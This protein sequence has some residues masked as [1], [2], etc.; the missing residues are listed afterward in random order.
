MIP[1]LSA[2]HNAQRRFAPTYIGLTILI[3][4]STFGLWLIALNMTANAAADF[5]GLILYATFGLSFL[6]DGVYVLDTVHRPLIT[7]V[8]TALRLAGAL[9]ILA[10]MLS[11]PT[12]PADPV[13]WALIWGAA[14][15]ILDVPWRQRSLSTLGKAVMWRM[16]RPGYP[17]IAAFVVVSS[18]RLIQILTLGGLSYGL[19]TALSQFI[20]RSYSSQ[21]GKTLTQVYALVIVPPAIL[22][23]N[24]LYYRVWRLA[25]RR[26][27]LVGHTESISAHNLKVQK[28]WLFVSLAVALIVLTY[29]GLQPVAPSDVVYV[30]LYAD[31]LGRTIAADFTGLSFEAPVLT[32]PQF[33]NQNT[34]LIR[35]LENLGSGTLRFGGNALEDTY[36]SAD[37]KPTSSDRITL[38]PADLDRLFSFARRIGWRVIL[39]VNLGHYDPEMAANESRYA[40]AVGGASLMAL[41][42]GN[43]PDLFMFNRQR[44]AL[45]AYSDFR[46][47]FDAYTQAIAPG[48]PI[49]GPTTYGATGLDWYPQ[50]LADERSH[51]ALATQHLYPLVRLPITAF[52]SPYTP[53]I[54]N[55]LSA[56]VMRGEITFID[57]AV[58]TAQMQKLPLQLDETNSVANW[59]K[60]GV[61][62]TFA[63]ALWGADHLFTMAEHGVRGLN[64]H[65]GWQ[66]Q[67]YTPICQD[68]NTFRA[69]PLYYGML[70][71]RYATPGPSQSL[72]VD[73]RFSS[74]NVA[75][76]VVRGG[77]GKLRIV[78][79]NKE[80]SRSAT[81]WLSISDKPAQATLIRL[82]A[83]TVEAKNGITF[84]GHAVDDAGNWSPE[85]GE[86]LPAPAG[87]FEIT[88]PAASA[89]VVVFN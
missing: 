89:A 56:N 26:W 65:A 72:P 41:E 31:A 57:Q 50:F 64:F 3:V 25:A 84:G 60:A 36:W 37:S 67:G 11:L 40:A 80:P 74:F 18:V 81:V 1:M 43:E 88:L 51:L 66:C 70:L 54:D 46:T 29:T 13:I 7:T 19:L 33:D 17:W 2:R 85:P 5:I 22:I 38:R 21:D 63:S 87:Q 6:A 45:W 30:Y 14:A 77:D 35:L 53:S 12:V 78:L 24:A 28:S 62:D 16:R 59:G 10:A 82:L 44:S 20:A 52:G 61:S 15:Y 42:I 49:A 34:I 79:I 39:G 48:V 58:N 9:L 8:E 23:A 71:F 76:H 75:V 47:E 69:Q 32:G 55:L 68:G 83:P 4:A 86:R 73:I 27:S